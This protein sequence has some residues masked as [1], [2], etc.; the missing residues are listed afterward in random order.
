MFFAQF[1]SHS[2][3]TKIWAL[4]YF[5]WISVKSEMCRAQQMNWLQSRDLWGM[6]TCLEEVAG[7]IFRKMRKDASWLMLS[8]RPSQGKGRRVGRCWGCPSPSLQ[9]SSKV[10]LQPGTSDKP[11][12][13]QKQTGHSSLVP[14]PRNQFWSDIEIR[15]ATLPSCYSWFQALSNIPFQWACCH[16]N[17]IVT[18]GHL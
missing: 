16:D 4:L 9:G 2:S 12:K 11:Q 6:E 8:G 17:L 1:L 10:H 15:C 7:E 5:W 14:H 3:Q 18:G 13:R